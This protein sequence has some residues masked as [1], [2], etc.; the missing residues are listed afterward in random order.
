MADPDLLG[1]AWL[2]EH[3][4]AF[5]VQPLPVR[6]Q[7]GSRRSTSTLDDQRVETY[8]ASARLDPSPAAHLNFMLKHEGVPLELLARVFDRIDPADLVSWIHDE[9]TGQ[10]ARRACFLF[11][12]ITGRLLPVGADV[13]G[14]NYVDALPKKEMVVAVA[15]VVNTRWRVRDNLPGT[16]HFCPVVRLTPAARKAAELDIASAFAEQEAEFGVEL[17]RRSAVW[18]TLRESRSSFVIEGEQD[19]T[20]RIQRF[21]AVLETRTGQGTVPLN[22]ESLA[23]L[24]EAILGKTTTLPTY[25]LRQSPVYVGQTVRYENVVHYVAP[26]WQVVAQ[27]VD[28]LREFLLRT[29]GASSVMR[30]AVASFG[31]VYIHPLSDGNGRMHR[32]LINDVLRRD[33]AVQAPFIL[34][35][36]ALITDS[37][38]ERTGYDTA[39]EAFSKPLMTRFADASSF[40]HEPVAQL[41]GVLSNFEF[42]EYADAMPAWRFIDLTSHV[43]YMSGVLDRTIRKEMHSQAAFFR[44][45]DRARLELKEVIEG[46]DAHLDT[47]IRSVR[48]NEGSLS[49]KLRGQFPQLGEP[50]VWSRVVRVVNGVFGDAGTSDIRKL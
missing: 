3:F 27:M 12:W 48:Q 32:F 11:E 13:A 25:G 31:F 39:L 19:Q 17:L 30:A 14:G 44:A 4:N 42:S 43:E 36:S 35:I 28:A 45:H 16:P 47:I 8:L 2:A 24:Q 41:D 21:A 10:Y 33:G 7:I 15:G 26:P 40:S 20:K 29:A 22:A 5:P 38:Q 46:P 9:P 37:P 6:S 50:A 34:P 18:L 1:G 49:N 23:E